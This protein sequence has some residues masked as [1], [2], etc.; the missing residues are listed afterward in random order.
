MMLASDVLEVRPVRRYPEPGYPTARDFRG[1]PTGPT[2]LAH[3][4]ASPTLATA[5]I[6]GAMGAGCD[7]PP[8]APT[9]RSPE[10]AP[11]VDTTPDAPTSGGAETAEAVTESPAATADAGAPPATATA[12][13]GLAPIDRQAV[14]AFQGPFSW[15]ASG[16][17]VVWTPY[18]TGAPARLSEEKVRPVVEQMFAQAGVRLRRDVKFTRPGIAV[19]LDGYNPEKRIGYEFVTWQD[20]E[21]PEGLRMDKEGDRSQMLSHDEIQRIM[22]LELQNKEHVAIISYQDARFAYQGRSGLT[23]TEADAMNAVRTNLRKYI[24]WLRSQGAL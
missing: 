19:E 9:A 22:Q 23:A 16:L 24:A 18:G 14:L 3:R 7:R 12:E 21:D 13:P 8:E 20:L 15:T 5:V 2:G 17:P 10:P 6:A 1:F 4:L 11:V